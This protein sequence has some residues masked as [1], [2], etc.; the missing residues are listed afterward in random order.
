MNLRE[1]DTVS[2]VAL[3]MENEAD[4]SAVVE[5]DAEGLE[6]IDELPA[7]GGA[8]AGAADGRRRRR[9]RPTRGVDPRRLLQ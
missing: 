1:D 5:G 7:D 8:A 3:V 9:R 4:T 2:A 6:P